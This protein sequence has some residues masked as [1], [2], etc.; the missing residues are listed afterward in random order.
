MA[1]SSLTCTRSPAISEDVV[2]G[3]EDAE[4]YIKNNGHT[5]APSLSDMPTVSRKAC[6]ADGQTFKLA[7]NNGPNHLHGGNKGFDKVVWQAVEEFR[8]RRRHGRHIP[9]TSP[10][11]EEGYPGTLKAQGR[12]P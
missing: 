2:L 7:T 4:G 6:H 8:N 11:G 10:D 5:W 3:Y 12:T 9:Y 1:E